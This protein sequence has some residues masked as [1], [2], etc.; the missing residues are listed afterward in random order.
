[1]QDV[2]RFVKENV[3]VPDFWD[4]RVTQSASD[5]ALWFNGSSYTYQ[6]V[7]ELANQFAHFALRTWQ[8]QKLQ[9]VA[10]FMRN[11]PEYLFAWLGLAKIGARVFHINVN[12]KD[13]QVVNIE[14]NPQGSANKGHT[15]VKG[16]FAHQ[17]AHSKDRL[18]SP[19]IKGPDGQFHKAT[20]DE[21]LDLIAT[22]FQA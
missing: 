5:P 14:P 18:D 10:L 8:L 16:R 9:P 20:W 12:V 1:V 15:C 19:L 4:W 11:Q 22:K 7:D 21:A 2:T 6:Q 17:F 3:T 13:G